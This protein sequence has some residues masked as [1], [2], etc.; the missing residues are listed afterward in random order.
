MCSTIA[1]EKW[2]RLL[3][4][5]QRVRGVRHSSL[6]PAY[7]IHTQDP[8]GGREGGGPRLSRAVPVRRS[9]SSRGLRLRLWALGEKGAPKASVLFSQKKIFRKI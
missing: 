4:N 2:L 9:F 6:R 7:K 8:E 3:R 1:I 5:D